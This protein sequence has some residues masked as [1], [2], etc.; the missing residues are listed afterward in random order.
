MEERKRVSDIS[1]Y[2]VLSASV[3]SSSCVWCCLPEV[4][5]C[6]RCPSLCSWSDQRWCIVVFKETL[7]FKLWFHGS[8]SSSSVRRCICEF[9]VYL[10]SGIAP[11]TGAVSSSSVVSK[12]GVGYQLSVFDWNVLCW[13]YSWL[14][15]NMIDYQWL[16]RIY[17]VLVDRVWFDRLI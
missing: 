4:F 3:N 8:S 13:L 12:T 5:V 15:V 14:A 16:V 10:S 7:Y 1:T 6:P 11:E 2:S 17:F 9:V